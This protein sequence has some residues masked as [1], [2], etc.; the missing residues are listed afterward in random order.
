MHAHSV[1][2]NKAC[3]I[4]HVSDDNIIVAPHPECWIMAYRLTPMA[5]H[6]Q[7]L[8]LSVFLGA[9]AQESYSI[10]MIKITVDGYGYDNA[11]YLPSCMV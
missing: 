5:W 4:I 2:N 8:S 10:N 9:W 6:L 11:D 7:L 3:I 1:L